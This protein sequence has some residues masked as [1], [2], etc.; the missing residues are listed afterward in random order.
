[1][2]KFTKKAKKEGY[3]ARSVFKLKWL[4]D[5]YKIIKKGDSVLDLG[6]YPGSW[7]Q[8]CL[9]LTDNIFGV[10]LKEVKIKNVVF[11]KKNVQDLNLDTKFDVILSD[12]APNTSGVIRLDQ[13]RSLDLANE[14]F[15]IVKKN[16]KKNGNFICKIFN[17]ELVRNFVKKLKKSFKLVKI[18]KPLASKKRSKEIFIVC[19]EYKW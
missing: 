10:D 7:L 2:D 13:E 11:F 8:Y 6:S 17:S 3:N 18:T 16:L 9:E 12:L 19:K 5:N 15:K 4:N 14:A 1:M